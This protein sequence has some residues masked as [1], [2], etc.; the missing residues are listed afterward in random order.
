[1][2]QEQRIYFHEII[3]E[4][5]DGEWG[6]DNSTFGNEECEVIRGTDFSSLYEPN[7]K[8]PKRWLKITNVKRKQLKTND[9]IFEMA[10][11]TSNQSTGRTSI[12]RASF[13]K[14]HKIFPV[15]CASFCRFLRIKNTYSPLY[16]YYLLQAWY[17]A[18][19]MRIFNIQHTGISRFQYTIFKNKTILNIPSLPIQKKIAAVLSAY[20][21]LIENNNKRIAILEKMAEELYREWFVR[22]RFPGYEKA[23]FVNGIPE[24]WEIKRI[25]DIGDYI[26]G[27]PFKPDDWKQQGL[28]IIKIREIKNG[29]DYDTP[30][31]SGEYVPKRLHIHKGD[32]IFSWSGSL[33]VIIWN[34][35]DGLL[36][37]HL[38]K[39]VPKP[40][41]PSM[42]LFLCLK[43]SISQFESLTT[44]ATMKHIKRKELNH[45]KVL[46]PKNEL[47]NGFNSIV[48]PLQKSIQN[49]S[50]QNSSLNYIK[51]S[52]L[53]RLMSGKIDVENLDIQFPK[54]MTEEE[55]TS[56][57]R[58]CGENN[59]A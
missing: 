12:V 31:N 41:I 6:I 24:G 17:K 55:K 52:L 23:K 14:Y 45:V 4:S 18:D 20:D 46:K 40:E 37:Q 50:T 54:S 1:M 36:N 2:K 39:V 19:Y 27:F 22:I 57:D 42:Y 53:T 47:L 29:I 25:G 43:S 15:L 11:G 32:I 3:E 33:E 9:I 58:I 38:F 16:I 8:L 7:Y 34:L 13:F 56:E 59:H 26:N 21:D 28:P 35:E 30:R 49:L 5:Y 10:G 48:E 51:Y 44:G